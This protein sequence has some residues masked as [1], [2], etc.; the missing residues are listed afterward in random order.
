VA[1]PQNI[2]HDGAGRNRV[3]QDHTREDRAAQDGARRDRSA[4]DRARRDYTPGDSP[5]VAPRVLL[6]R[7]SPVAAV[8]MRGMLSEE[9]IEIVG[10]ELRP[11]AIERR[12]RE[13]EPDVVVLALE[14]GGTR[15][16]CDRIKL[17]APN[18]TVIM[19]AAEENRM[20][21]LAPGEA[22]PREVPGGSSADLRRELLCSQSSTTKE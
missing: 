14:A 17:A 15:T 19:W 20:Q 21:I 13:L 3:D 9:G 22:T 6:A 16:L 8:G 10:E 5:R 7:L 2:L 12:A 1:N 4:Q 11:L 18:A